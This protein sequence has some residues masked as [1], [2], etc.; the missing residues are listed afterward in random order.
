MSSPQTV[1]TPAAEDKDSTLAA[2]MKTL[3]GHKSN[4]TDKDAAAK[5][6]KAFQSKKAAAE[7]VLKGLEAEEEEVTKEALRAFGRT[8][9]TVDGV[10]YVPTGRGERLYYKRGGAKGLEL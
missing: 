7:A 4:K 3:N 8:K 6:F 1:G 5:K 2:F 10:D 9:L